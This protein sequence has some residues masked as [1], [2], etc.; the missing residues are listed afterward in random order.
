MGK[1]GNKLC[2]VLAYLAVRGSGSGFI[3]QFVNGKLLTK[4]RFIDFVC[5]ALD[6]AGLNAKDYAGHSFCIS[7]ATTASACGLNVSVIQMLGRWSSSA[8]LVYIRTP[9]EQLANL[10]SVLGQS[11]A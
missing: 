3:F 5:D 10:S 11:S 8:Y 2:P 1:N 7:A 4:T 9:R 6:K